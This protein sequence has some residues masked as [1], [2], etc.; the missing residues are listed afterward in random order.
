MSLLHI[1]EHI[2]NISILFISIYCLCTSINQSFFLETYLLKPF[3]LFSLFPCNS[4]FL[5][6]MCSFSL[7]FCLFLS[8]IGSSVFWI[9]FFFFPLS[10]FTWFLDGTNSLVAS[11]ENT[12]EVKFLK[13]FISY[14]MDSLVGNRS[15]NMEIFALNFENI[16]SLSSI[17]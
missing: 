14:L 1:L 12:C 8:S 6:L 3:F 15:W 10:W 9:L 11:W 4:C 17:F 2:R 13:H 5:F 16:D 7:S